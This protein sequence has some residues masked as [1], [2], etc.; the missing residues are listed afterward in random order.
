MKHRPN[1]KTLINRLSTAIVI[2]YLHWELSLELF[3]CCKISNCEQFYTLPVIG[4]AAPFISTWNRSSIFKINGQ[5]MECFWR[6]IFVYFYQ[7]GSIV[8]NLL[9]IKY[10]KIVFTTF[11]LYFINNNIIWHICVY[12]LFIKLKEDFA[13][14]TLNTRDYE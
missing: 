13:N 11:I 10:M 8:L 12:L 1:K 14:M 9:R 3:I 2:N 7:A 6:Q 5:V 4:G